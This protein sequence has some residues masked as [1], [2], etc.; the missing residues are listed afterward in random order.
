[1]V[2]VGG[3]P[4]CLHELSHA[5]SYMYKYMYMYWIIFIAKYHIV[6]MHIWLSKLDI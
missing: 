2:G 4:H 5:H 3:P 1:M 6:V